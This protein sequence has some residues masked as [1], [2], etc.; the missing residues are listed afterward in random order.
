VHGGL[1]GSR[2]WRELQRRDDDW[3]VCELCEFGRAARSEE[4]ARATTAA[5][6]ENDHRSGF[7]LR[8]SRHALR[9]VADLAASLGPGIRDFVVQNR[10]RYTFRRLGDGHQAVEHMHRYQAGAQL[11]G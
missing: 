9:H 1:Q 8:D 7:I 2:C 10:G 6:A 4:R 5:S 3:D 11:C